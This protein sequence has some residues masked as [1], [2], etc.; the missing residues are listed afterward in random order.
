MRDGVIW[1]TG[2][3]A[4]AAA[5]FVLDPK[6][7][8]RRRRRMRDK[9]VRLTHRTGDLA[10]TTTR[11]LRNRTLGT[12]ASVRRRLHRSQPDDTILEER[13]RAAMGRVVSHPHAIAVKASVGRVML[14]GRILGSEEAP[15]IAVVRTVNG[16]RQVE[17]RLR[18]QAEPVSAPALQGSLARVRRLSGLDLFQRNWSP[19]TRALIGGTGAGLLGAGAVRRGGVGAGLAAAG[20]LLAARAITN[21][22]FWRLVGRRERRT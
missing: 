22:P 18:R 2:I 17:T 3:G 1:L 4:G 12:V 13:V 8:R 20:A 9:A 19:A 21:A 11:D 7:G 5:T 14:E 15:L 6:S 16:V 10:S